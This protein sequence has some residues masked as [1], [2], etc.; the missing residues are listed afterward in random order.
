MTASNIEL[1]KIIAGC[2]ENNR[3]SQR[4]LYES[5][6]PRLYVVCRRYANSEEEAEDILMEGFM[7][8]FKN[9]KSYRGEGAFDKWIQSVMVRSAI[10]HYRS[11]KHYRKELLM[12]E[13]DENSLVS[14]DTTVF[15]TLEAK[16]I[17]AL[18]EKCPATERTVFNMKAIDGFSFEEIAKTLEKKENAVRIAY[19]RACNRLMAALGIEYQ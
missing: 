4:E 15:G 2:I 8:V 10:S 16:Q 18:L 19:M 1:E 6:A 17:L 13:M 11:T 7:E 12:D 14:E 9:L 3:L 5:Y